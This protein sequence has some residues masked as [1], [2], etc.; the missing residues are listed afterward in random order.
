MTTGA[1]SPADARRTW[2]SFEA[3]H[4]MIY[5]T[6]LASEEYSAVGVVKN[7]P[8]YFASRS[9][10]MG[11]V[12]AEV[13]IATFYNFHHGLVRHAMKGVWDATTPSA[14]LDARLR[15]AD[16]SLRLAFDHTVIASS[17]FTSAVESL[18]QAAMVACERPE[19]RPLFAGHAALAW[20]DEPVQVLWHAQTLLRE[21]RGDG[22][23]AALTTE[24]LS[25]L[26]ALI[27]HAASGDVPGEVLR[28][29]RAFSEDEWAAGIESMAARGLVDASG[30]FTA[31]GRA[32]RDRI[33]ATTDALAVAPYAALGA[34][35]C[36]ALRP[37]GRK[38]S[39]LIVAAGLMSVDM[40]RLTD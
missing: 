25:G 2:R 7:R 31:E 24:G 21:Y 13:V 19:G 29:T 28:L 38:L 39:E 27:S 37:V 20:P 18:R 14:L 9:A 11:A 23:I 8:G 5:F 34:D 35:T 12:N 10:A 26:D 1:I 6:T 22:H 4:G 33:E 3:V 16:R 40:D 17:E 30:A 32:Q 36:A 15:A